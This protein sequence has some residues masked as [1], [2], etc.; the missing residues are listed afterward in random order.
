MIRS[1]FVSNSSSSSFIIVGKKENCVKDIDEFF[2]RIEANPDSNVVIIPDKEMY[3]GDNVFCPTKKQ[4]EW[5]VKNKNDIKNEIG[6]RNF[7]AIFDPIYNEEV[8][9]YDNPFIDVDLDVNLKDV[10]IVEVEKDYCSFN[11]Y[12]P[13]EDFK[14]YFNFDIESY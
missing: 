8:E 9:S 3:D 4:I 2:E 13:Y 10:G 1:G 6:W 5:L 7:K 11:E 14:Y 12:T